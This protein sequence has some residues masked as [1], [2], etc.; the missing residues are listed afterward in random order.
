MYTRHALTKKRL[1]PH[2]HFTAMAI[3]TALA[4]SSYLCPFSNYLNLHVFGF[5]C[6]SKCNVPCQ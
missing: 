5:P 2:A 4:A 1:T 6:L 3:T